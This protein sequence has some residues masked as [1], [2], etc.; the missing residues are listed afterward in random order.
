[1]VVDDER[2]FFRFGKGLHRRQQRLIGEHRR[3]L[4]DL[5]HVCDQ[6][7]AAELALDVFD[8]LRGLVRG[9]G[10]EQVG[11]RGGAV[12]DGVAQLAVVDKFRLVAADGD[13]DVCTA[14]DQVRKVLG[15]LAA[16]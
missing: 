14:L 4:F 5:E 12:D 3:H 13:V 6:R 16:V 1:M 9:V 8:V 10:D 11:A 7:R 15:G 2:L